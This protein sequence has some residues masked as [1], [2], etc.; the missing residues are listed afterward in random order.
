MTSTVDRATA[1]FAVTAQRAGQDEILQLRGE[2]TMAHTH[3]LRSLIRTVL[4]NRDPGRL[5]LDLSKLK[6]IDSSG[7]AVMMWAHFRLAE[8]GH[9]LCLAA[10]CDHVLRVLRITGLHQRLLTRRTVS[11]ALATAL[12]AQ[13]PPISAA[14]PSKVAGGVPV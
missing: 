3:E 9:L 13:V 5:V 1:L 2:L 12:D 10:P 11:A 8:R 4:T 6:F 14:Q 7:V